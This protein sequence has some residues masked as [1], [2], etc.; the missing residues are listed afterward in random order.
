MK[1]TFNQPC[2]FFF[3]TINTVNCNLE[4]VRNFS[5]K[6]GLNKELYDFQGLERTLCLN[7]RF[8]YAPERF[9]SSSLLYCT[10]SAI[11]KEITQ[12]FINQLGDEK[13]RLTYFTIFLTFKLLTD[14]HERSNCMFIFNFK[15]LYG[16][17]NSVKLKFFLSAKANTAN[18]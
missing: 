4:L 3:L 9:I 10:V 17:Q 12:Q 7:I 11:R 5:L 6:R 1:R 8:S 2:F 18:K 16:L 15:T 13:M 14:K